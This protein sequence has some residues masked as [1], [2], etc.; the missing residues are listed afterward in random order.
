MGSIDSTGR[1]RV[2]KKLAV[3]SN[4]KIWEAI[5][6]ISVALEC[7]AVGPDDRERAQKGTK[8]PVG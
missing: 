3:P 5:Q 2:E 1:D 6:A 4:Q 7:P 8:H